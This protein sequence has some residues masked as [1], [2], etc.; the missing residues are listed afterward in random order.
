MGDEVSKLPRCTLQDRNQWIDAGTT[1]LQ[2]TCTQLPSGE[3]GSSFEFLTGPRGPVDAVV[4]VTFPLGPG[5]TWDSVQ[6]S[7]YDHAAQKISEQ[8]RALH[9]RGDIS[10]IEVDQFVNQRNA[11]KQATR[12]KLSP[13]GKQFSKFLNP[14][15]EFKDLQGLLKEKGSLEAVL[16]GVGRTRTWV[17]RLSFVG[18]L[19]GP[20]VLVIQIKLS[21]DTIAS[22]D[23]GERWRVGIGEAAE[24]TGGAVGGWYGAGI[25]CSAGAAATVWLFGVG[26]AA[27]CAVGGI[28]GAV[29]LGFAAGKTLRFA[30]E[31]SYDGGRAIMYWIEEQ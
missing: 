28:I 8:A 25:G 5:L 31:E 6:R 1:N 21:A 16:K 17:N 26:G 4:D 23:E 24:I 15:S 20:T 29:G 22:A 11:L 12:S 13:L 19:A 14:S 2:R 27:G 9:A 3:Q 30:A 10:V 7:L 18:R